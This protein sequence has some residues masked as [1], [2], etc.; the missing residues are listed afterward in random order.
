MLTE[1]L[2]KSM[3]CFSILYFCY[4]LL[5]KKSRSYFANRFLLLFSVFFSLLIPVANISTITASEIALIKQNADLLNALSYQNYFPQQT[6]VVLTDSKSLIS[7]SLALAIIY[8]ATALVLMIRF[9][10]NIYT[11]LLKSYK[12]EKVNHQQTKLTLIDEP[13]NP[14]TFFKYL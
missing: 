7:L 5:L 14:F 9:L 1:Y 12:G 11:L 6:S 8:I 13:I 2:I 10:L 4:I 3:F